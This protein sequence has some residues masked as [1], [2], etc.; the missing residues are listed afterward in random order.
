[1]NRKK[2]ESRIFLLKKNFLL[3][4]KKKSSSLDRHQMYFSAFVF[5]LATVFV[6]V[7]FGQKYFVA[8]K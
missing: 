3:P 4:F 1:M 2:L 8:L 7:H 6:S 5:A